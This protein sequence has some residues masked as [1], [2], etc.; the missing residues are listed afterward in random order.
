MIVRVFRESY[1]EHHKSC[2]V[3]WCKQDSRRLQRTGPVRSHRD[4]AARAP[5]HPGLVEFELQRL[6]DVAQ[7]QRAVLT[8]AHAAQRAAHE[9]LGQ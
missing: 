6:D 1:I 9:D 4:P 2:T 5:Q 3:Q 7:R 8:R